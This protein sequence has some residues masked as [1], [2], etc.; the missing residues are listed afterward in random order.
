MRRLEAV[1][2]EGDQ[3]RETRAAP[4]HDLGREEGSLAGDRGD[5]IQEHRQTRTHHEHAQEVEGLTRL[6]S[7]RGKHPRGIRQC[8]QAEREVDEEDPVPA[9]RVD[10]IATENRAEDRAQQ[11]RDTEDGHQPAHPVRARGAGHDRHAERHEEATTEALE[12]A[13]EDELVD[14]AG[15]GAEDRSDREERER[16]HVQAFGAEAVGGPAS[17]RDDRGQGEGIGRDRPGDRR[18]GEIFSTLG[19]GVLEGGQ[20]DIDD[21]D[22]EDRHDRTQDDD[23]GDLEDRAVD[24]VGVV[25]GRR[26]GDLRRTGHEVSGFR[27]VREGDVGVGA[28]R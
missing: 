21:G 1:D 24:L 14:R 5:A 19:E 15:R 9:D 8:Q 7:V 22:V 23:T 18:I 16:H 6:G 3:Q 20:G 26:M 25:A 27:R 10:E 11:H 12:N 13:I 4:A 2:D 17:Q 28:S